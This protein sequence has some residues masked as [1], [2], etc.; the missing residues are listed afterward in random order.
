MIHTAMRDIYDRLKPHGFDA[1]FV[2]NCILP[3][4]WEDKLAEVPANRQYAEAVI[5][6]QLGI[7]MS[8]LRDQSVPL[9]IRQSAHLKLK[10]RQGAT[11]A[12]LK[13]A[14]L[15]GERIAK[16]AAATLDTPPDL[17]DL[18]AA[19]IRRRI[20]AS[21]A[22]WVGFDELLDF[23]WNIG[24]PVMRLCK[25]P[26]GNKKPDGMAVWAE[27]RPAIVIA[28]GR[29]HPA[30]HIFVIAHELG[31]IV[32]G[33][34]SKG[35]VSMDPKVELDSTERHEAEANTFAV[36]LLSGHPDLSFSPRTRTMN[37]RQLAASA[38]SIGKELRIDPGFLILSYSRSKGYYALAGAALN[39]LHPKTDVCRLY[40]SPYERLKISDTT[41]DNRHVFECL[42]EAA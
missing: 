13:V 33:H 30:W 1:A 31:H 10:S 23:C 4:W 20:L 28:S 38:I 35:E 36:E 34:L 6:R 26:E 2:R 9:K 27:E 32:L 24:V 12:N 22:D 19:S 29:K 37:A 5:S 3:D 25:L 42:T 17:H 14:R 41:E 39:A 18:T 11:Q 16:I 40:Q 15:L 21:G 8:S 7:E